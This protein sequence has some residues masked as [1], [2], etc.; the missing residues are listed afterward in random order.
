MSKEKKELQIVETEE[1]SQEEKTELGANIDRLIEAHKNNRQTINRLVFESVAAMTEA[2]D[3]ATTLARRG[4]FKRWAGG[5][6]GTNQKLQ[7]TINKNRSAAQYAAQLTLQKL[8]EQ[9]VMTFDLITAV[10]NKL[11]ASLNRVDNEFVALYQGLKK[12][13]NY[14][15]GKLLEIEDRLDKVERNLKLERWN[16]TIRRRM[17]GDIEYRDL[18]DISKIVCLTRDFYEI[19]KGEWSISDLT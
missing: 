18:D 5:I 11:N 9:N 19:S 4:L 1:L 14:N 3:A 7:N 6:T 16:T 2:D 12:F 15:R 13:F 17:F 10:N 8:A